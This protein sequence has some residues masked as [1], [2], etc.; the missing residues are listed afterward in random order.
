VGDHLEFALKYDGINLGIL[1][2]WFGKVSSE[3]AGR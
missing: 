3:D 1:A 2:A